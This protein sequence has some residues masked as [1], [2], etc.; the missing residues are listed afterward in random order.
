MRMRDQLVV[1]IAVAVA[2]VAVAANVF[3]QTQASDQRVAME[4]AGLE[5]AWSYPVMEATVATTTTS[6][7]AAAV[8]T[9]S[10]EDDDHGDRPGAAT[11]SDDSRAP[12][13][14]ED[15]CTVQELL[16][17]D[18]RNHGQMVSSY[19]DSLGLVEGL[20]GPMGFYIRQIAKPNIDEDGPPRADR[21]EENKDTPPGQDK[22]ETDKDT[23]PGQDKKDK[24]D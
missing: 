23:P 16:D 3:A 15:P 9:S 4:H 2:T 14:D 7:S 5:A 19:V 10:E 20:D 11:S 24:D 1:I 18:F 6:T 8:P 21:A 13:S 12:C 17:R 22:D